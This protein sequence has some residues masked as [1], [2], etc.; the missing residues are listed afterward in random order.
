[1]AQKNEELSTPEKVLGAEGINAICQKYSLNEGDANIVI[2]ILRKWE[3]LV[4]NPQAKALVGVEESSKGSNRT[5]ILQA[6]NEI[7]I[8]F[9]S[10]KTSS[11]N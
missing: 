4:G 1:M 8:E 3:N 10:R 11:R 2:T 7:S 5:A 9:S 6:M